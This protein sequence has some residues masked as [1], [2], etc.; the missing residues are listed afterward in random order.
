MLYLN[1]PGP[2]FTVGNKRQ[3]LLSLGYIFS[4][5]GQFRNQIFLSHLI[6]RVTN[7]FTVG[8][9]CIDKNNDEWNTLDFVPI[10]FKS[11]SYVKS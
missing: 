7:D 8:F 10:T 11:S 2:A 3:M 1:D 4:K 9:R 6:W 5:K